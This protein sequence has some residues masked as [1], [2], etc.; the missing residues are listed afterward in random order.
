MGFEV[1]SKHL[2]P[3]MERAYFWEA[4]ADFSQLGCEILV[5]WCVAAVVLAAVFGLLGYIVTLKLQ[6]ARCRRAAERMG[7]EYARILQEMEENVGSDRSHVRG[8]SV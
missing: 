6:T 3:I 7:V 2:N 1:F 4:L 5:R 8:N